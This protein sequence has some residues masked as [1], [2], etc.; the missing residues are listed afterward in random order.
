[1]DQQWT[2]IDGNEAAARVA[3]ALSEVLAVYPITPSTPMGEAADGWAAAGKPNLWGVV[4]DVVEMQSEAGAAGALHGALQRGALSASFTA[5]Q[6]LLLMIPNM[7]KI[8]GE[9]TPAV[10]H[11]AA[12][13]VA[14]H[15]LSIFGDHSDVMH[16]RTTGWAMLA[17]ASVQEAQDMALIAHVATLR[18]RVPFIHF[19]DGFRT[20]HEIN[21]IDLVSDD[22]LRALAPEEDILA[23]RARGLS[24]D[25]PLV[26][27]TAQNPDAFF[28]GREAGNPFYLATPGIVAAA[29]EAFERRTGRHYGLVEYAGAPDAERV[30][31]LMGS[32]IGAT[33]QTMQTLAAAGERVGLVKVRL[34]RPFPTE[35]F[36]AAL[37]QTVRS[38]A[39]L[40]RTKE[41]GAPGEPL[42]L[43]LVAALAEGMDSAHPRFE[44]MPRVIGG[45]Y[46]LS[47]KEF[48][49]GMV[50]AVFDELAA[51]HPKRHFTVGI[52]DDVTHLSIA[53]DTEFRYRRPAGEVQAMFFGTGSDGTVGANKNS[54]KIIGENTDLWAQGYFVYDSKK[55][56]SVTVSHL[57][58]GPNPIRS[59]Y[60][61]ERAD[62][63]ACHQ[64]GLLGKLNVLG[65][66]RDGAT[67][68][69]N[70]PFPAD[71]VWDHL[72]ECIQEHLID[73]GI[74]FW[75]IDA[76]RIAAEVG[77]GSRINTVMQPCFFA[78]SGVLPVD[79]AVA[80]IKESVEKA[81]G[82]RGPVIVERNFA[83][84]DRSLKELTQV[85][86]PGSVTCGGPSGIAVPDDA[87]D[88]VRRVI[89]PLLAGEGDLLPVSAFPVDGS[90][91]TGTAKYEKRAIAR[92]IPIWDPELCIDCG[93]CALVCPHAVIRMKVYEPA[94][95]EGAPEGFRSKDFR[96][97]DLPGHK[98]TIQM[99]PDDCTRCGVCVN[100]CPAKSK[101]EVRRRAIGMEPAMGRRDA[102]RRNWQFFDSIPPLAR[103]LLPRASVRGSQVLEP[104]FEFSGA[105]AGCGETPYVKLVSQLFGDRIVVANSTGCSS[106]YGGNLPTTPWTVD[107]DGR[108]PAWN[109]SLFEDTA[110][111]GMGMRM[112]C[113]ARLARARLLLEGLA[114]RLDGALVRETIEAP[115]DTELQLRAQRQ[116]VADLEQALEG[117]GNDDP[118]VPHLLALAGDLVSKGVWI[119]GGDGWAYD[120]GFGGLDHV[121][122]S[123]R[124]V[125]IMVLDTEVYSNTGGQASKATPR[126]AVAKFAS[127]G[128]AT[129]KK[130]L[131]ALAMA[132]G[133]AY[134]AQI[135]LGANDTQTVKALLEA[136]AWPGPSLVIAYSTCTA[137]GMD[138][139]KSMEHM[140]NAVR[141][142]YWPLYRFQPTATESG[143]PFK[144]D[145]RKPSIPVR[146][147][148]SSEA[149]FAILSR[150]HPQRSELLLELIQADVDERWRYYEQLA[151]MSRKVPSAEGGTRTDTGSADSPQ[152][153]EDPP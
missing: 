3:Y 108:G 85:E 100:V 70:S 54:V 72:P 26:R 28:Q 42:Y 139:S 67:F 78:L 31:V 66:A 84:I 150:T 119:I 125:N 137:H 93:K 120:I 8:A 92:E 12:R 44:R 34:Y 64:F 109:N 63:V 23:F 39:V 80:H 90:F 14:T 98:L 142:G 121:L 49:P 97:K 140:K 69:L 153:E 133:T 4:P 82:K 21:S 68:L 1:M 102:E 148:V 62:F 113:E 74:Q 18:A 149:R 52:T 27:G 128:K 104:L 130:D 36:V 114:P 7:F 61:I 132:Y 71:E 37:P 135:A 10:I 60:L 56:G 94:R 112:G 107:R 79:E 20:S 144:L 95:L 143:R 65:H 32:G 115:Q 15:A 147:F 103:D 47:S 81:Y 91:I 55:A 48:N 35:Q 129:P 17:S 16:A 96:S 88:F 127:S 151:V 5:S 105:C 59:T 73:K 43:D 123:G 87:P 83:A 6:G 76:D 136:D 106:I 145:S 9:L 110:E 13:T 22:D 41:P 111:F 86:A 11:V 152:H 101:T 116:R 25:A 50:K 53:P 126:G 51:E 30:V 38:I 77:M 99:A 146:D 40:D 122:A 46:G 131:G 117:L 58:F 138:M 141:S 33:E 45:R 2:C 118:D 24:P 75:V 29:M 124:N 89:V 134:V 57:R 19:F